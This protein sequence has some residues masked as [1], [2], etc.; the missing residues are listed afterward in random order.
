MDLS[1]AMGKKFSGNLTIF[2]D[3]SRYTV[4]LYSSHP[5]LLWFPSPYD[6]PFQLTG[7]K[8]TPIKMNIKSFTQ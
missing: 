3:I 8:H 1:V 2:A 7:G 5:L 6:S 4:K